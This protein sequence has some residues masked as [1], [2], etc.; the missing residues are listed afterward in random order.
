VTALD[1][2][3]Q[4]QCS[5]HLLGDL[6]SADR[7]PLIDRDHDRGALPGNR[8]YRSLGGRL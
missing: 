6:P 7:L 1:A 3:L 2:P 8:E 4:T 5:D